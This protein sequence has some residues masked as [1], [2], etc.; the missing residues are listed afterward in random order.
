MKRNKQ[1]RLSTGWFRGFTLI[2]LWV[3]I[4]IIAILAAILFPVFAQAREAARKTS[5]TSNL[6]QL[7]LG[8]QMY[9]QDYDGKYP[10]W[11]WGANGQGGGNM[12]SLWHVAIFPYVKNVQLYSC[13][14]D[15][16]RWGQTTTD[17]YWWSIPQASRIQQAPMFESTSPN[18]GGGEDR[19]VLSYGIGETFHGAGWGE[20]SLFAPASTAVLSEAPCLLGDLWGEDNTPGARIAM[21]FAASKTAAAPWGQGGT[22]QWNPAWDAN[23][24]HQGG[25][26]VAYADGHA[27]WIRAEKMRENLTRPLN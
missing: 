11:S 15:G 20:S 26:N 19:I 14:S 6:R 17:L 16:Q 2:E 21:R 13:P 3:V 22:Y 8:I 24:R 5:C 23:T 7:G 25:I 27:K 10:F 1:G 4:A 18:G 12:V 9:T